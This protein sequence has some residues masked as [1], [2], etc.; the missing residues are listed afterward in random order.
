MKVR[1]PQSPVTVVAFQA[2]RDSAD[3]VFEAQTLANFI[4]W[5]ADEDPA[6]LGTTYN[7]PSSLWV[8]ETLLGDGKTPFKIVSPGN[9]NPSDLFTPSTGEIPVVLMAYGFGRSDGVKSISGGQNVERIP[10]ARGN[11]NLVLLHVNINGPKGIYFRKNKPVI[12]WKT[13]T[14]QLRTRLE[15]RRVSINYNSKMNLKSMG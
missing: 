13:Q 1:S 10:A 15:I 14:T 7:K 5:L 12:S 2:N 6:K 4:K 11:K 9:T 3:H 8:E